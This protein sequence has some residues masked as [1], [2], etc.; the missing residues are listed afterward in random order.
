MSRLL[1]R[2]KMEGRRNSSDV[3]EWPDSVLE[4]DSDGS[5]TFDSASP[6][7]HRNMIHT[8]HI[9]SCNSSSSPPIP[10]ASPG[11]L[12]LTNTNNNSVDLPTSYTQHINCDSS[13][14]IHPRPQAAR[15]KVNP[16]A[17]EDKSSRACKNMRPKQRRGSSVNLTGRGRVSP[18][19]ASDEN[20]NDS[21][22][23]GTFAVHRWLCRL[24][25][26]PVFLGGRNIMCKSA[27][28]VSMSV[29]W[30]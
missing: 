2:L 24:L 25:V 23:Q 13:G 27:H 28:T 30:Q 6:T 17:R 19:S 18:L 14:P 3:E 5:F 15:V 20:L 1:G 8:D 21:F 4:E 9:K 22:W 16:K 26:F 10:S 12:L 7:L 11:S 29:D